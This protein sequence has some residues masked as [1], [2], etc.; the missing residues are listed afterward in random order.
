MAIVSS[1][2]LAF[3]LLLLGG[4]SSSA[5]SCTPMNITKRREGSSYR[6]VLNPWIS[7]STNVTNGSLPPG[8][9]PFSSYP[10]INATCKDSITFITPAIPA[11]QSVHGVYL[12]DDE[13]VDQHTG[14]YRCPSTAVDVDLRN[15]TGGGFSN[16]GACR[17]R[18]IFQ[19]QIDGT[20]NFTASFNASGNCAGY[21]TLDP[22]VVYTVG[23]PT[24]CSTATVNVTQKP[25]GDSCYTSTS[26]TVKL[27]DWVKKPTK[28]KYLAFSCP[29]IIG[30]QP[31]G[32][33]S[34]C[35]GKMTVVVKVTC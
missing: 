14:A 29:Q 33:T 23:A 3:G 32:A 10:M 8:T 7:P 4:S 34:H 31:G 24:T 35:H 6:H 25:K 22:L 5:Q 18:D 12:I 17:G 19:V 13:F 27:K 28:L 11:R 21:T 30:N 9:C 1:V 2:I 16:P 15:G 26:Y 20:R